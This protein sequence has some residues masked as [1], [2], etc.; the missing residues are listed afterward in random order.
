MAKFKDYLKQHEEMLNHLNELKKELENQKN[1]TVINVLKKEIAS[2][3]TE[4][5]KF[6]EQSLYTEDYLENERLW[7]NG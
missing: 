1:T 3:E 4:L 7:R 6:M 2:K 5:K